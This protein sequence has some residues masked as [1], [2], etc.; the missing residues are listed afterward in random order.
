MQRFDGSTE[1][2]QVVVSGGRPGQQQA[3]SRQVV[4]SANVEA[5]LGFMAS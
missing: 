5:R 2:L 4:S 3:V 1:L